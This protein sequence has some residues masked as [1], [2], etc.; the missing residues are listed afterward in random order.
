MLKKTVSTA[1]CRPRTEKFKSDM[2]KEKHSAMGSAFSDFGYAPLEPALWQTEQ[3]QKIAYRDLGIRSSSS[4]VFVGAHVRTTGHGD[5][6]VKLGAD[7]GFA[8]V[9][10]LC[11]RVTITP[12]EG[13]QIGLRGLDS[14][15]RYGAGQPALVKF[16][17]DAEA[18]IIGSGTTPIGDFGSDGDGRW[19]VSREEEDA[20]LV[21]DGPRS[22]FRYR[23]LGVDDATD[24]RVHVHLVRATRPPAEGGTGY[25][26][27][28]MGQFFYVL[29]GW[30]DLVVKQHPSVR[31]KAGD[32]MCLAQRMKHDVPDF[33]EDYLVLEMCVPA[34]YD[35]VDE[36]RQEGPLFG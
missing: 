27:H 29:R 7:M 12:D 5:G 10:V 18:L 20:Y 34:D 6:S 3:D 33:S 23:N 8:F 2:D 35:T 19:A 30:V 11:G 36:P 16:S 15:V 1:E 32:G 25:H 24:R 13:E 14:A 28:S 21:G 22:F 9:F 31:M 26:S 4:E 17:H